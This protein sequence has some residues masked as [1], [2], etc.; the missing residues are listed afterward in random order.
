MA[1]EGDTVRIADPGHGT[2]TSAGVLLHTSFINIPVSAGLVKVT[3][4]SPKPISAWISAKPEQ[5]LAAALSSTDF[6]HHVLAVFTLPMS[7]I[8]KCMYPMFYYSI[9]HVLLVQDQIPELLSF[10]SEPFI[11]RQCLDAFMFWM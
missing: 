11:C 7:L 4:R 1:G 8:S 9:F 5:C 2:N 3:S 10:K 6:N